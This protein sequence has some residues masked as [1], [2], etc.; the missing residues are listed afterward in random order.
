MHKFQQRFLAAAVAK[1]P[2][3]SFY[4]DLLKA[5]LLFFSFLFSAEKR[6]EKNQKKRKAASRRLLS[7]CKKKEA[8]KKLSRSERE[9]SR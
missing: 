9:P 3:F 8:K 4:H 2:T 5:G 1:N 7:S 6:K